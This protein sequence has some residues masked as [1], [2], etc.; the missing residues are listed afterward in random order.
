MGWELTLDRLQCFPSKFPRARFEEAQ[1]IQRIYNKLYCAVSEDEECIFNAIEDLIP[2]EPLAAAL[3]DIYQTV[4]EEGF[5]QDT[6]LGVF[7][8][9]YML[10]VNKSE[11]SGNRDEDLSGCELMQ[12]E[13]NTFSCSGASHAQKVAHMHHFLSR[14]GLYDT[15]KNE[16][17]RESLPANRN[18]ESLA[19]S[20]SAA[21]K[22][23]GPPRS[24]LA[25][26]TAVLFIVQPYNVRT[27]YSIP[28]FAIALKSH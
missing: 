9:D 24:K 5:V 11:P 7:R 26:R 25:K 23:Y 18:I 10:H 21:H 27:A 20:I 6:S 19:S 17:S 12:V 2:T 22:L 28:S 16:F 4:K 13:F 14:V 8:S 15:S 1:H 3:W